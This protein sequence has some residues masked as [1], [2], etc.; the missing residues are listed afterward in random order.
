MD[1]YGSVNQEPLYGCSNCYENSLWF[2]VN[3]RVYEGK[4]WCDSCWDWQVWCDDK[5]PRWRELAPFVPDDTKRIAELELRLAAAEADAERWRTVQSIA[6]LDGNI[7]GN[8][9]AWVIWT[10]TSPTV[11][12]NHVPSLK[13]IIDEARGG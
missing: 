11:S 5:L 13:Q 7:R 4:C 1:E 9:Y 6:V 2:A 12:E 3:L 10:E 8:D